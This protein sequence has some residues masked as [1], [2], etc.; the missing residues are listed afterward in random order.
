MLD[1]GVPIEVVSKLM[2]HTNIGITLRYYAHLTEKLKYD[3][4]SVLN[5]VLQQRAG[6][7]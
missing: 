5:N 6:G 1:N 3:A 4:L 7:T 2:R